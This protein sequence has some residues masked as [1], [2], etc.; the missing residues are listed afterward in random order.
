MAPLPEVSFWGIDVYTFRAAAK[1][2]M[3][4]ED[5]YYEPN[6]LRFADGATVGNIHDYIYAPSFAFALRPLAWLSPENASRVWFALNL[7]LFFSS[8][9]LLLRA[10]RWRPAPRAF[11]GIMS[12]L[13]LYPP[14]RTAL[15]IGQSTI[16]LLF[17][18]SLSLYLLRRQ[19]PLAGGLAFSLGLFKPHLY[20]LIA[21]LALARRWRWLAGVGL[22]LAI[23]TLPFLSWVDNWL[24]AAMSTRE[25]NLAVGQC[26][27]MVSLVSLLDCTLSWPG[28]LLAGLL[29]VV[30]LA[31][32][33]GLWR[34]VP[35]VDG[36]PTL[37]ARTFDRALAIM[38]TASLLLIDHTRVAD[39]MLL[40][41]PLLVVWRDWSVLKKPW[42]QRVAVALTLSVYV[43]PYT[44]DILALRQIAFALPF[45]YIG[46]S[47]AT[48]G[49]LLLQWGLH[50]R[51][52]NAISIA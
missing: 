15:I 17:F 42:Q 36:S 50:F 27:Q 35:Q 23:L 1:A 34:T 48:L 38:I 12:G 49:L 43:L 25:A 39:Q 41:F 28:W 14:L 5:P 9:A 13:V 6:I 26:F 31:A 47:G 20:P 37:K 22:G 8:T 45:W 40:V 46:L 33:L 16:L 30:V 11:L 24:V 3:V 19:K 52:A 51:R 10:L 18:L 32:S 2:M 4:G 44:L 29:G 21:L 7:I